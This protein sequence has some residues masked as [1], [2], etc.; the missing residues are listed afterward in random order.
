MNASKTIKNFELTFEGQG[1]PYIYEIAL[2]KYYLPPKTISI[3]K[4]GVVQEFMHK[5]TL[6]D[7]NQKG[8]TLTSKIVKGF[9]K[10]MNVAVQKSRHDIKEILKKPLT[11]NSLKRAFINA[12]NVTN[13]Y[14]FFDPHFFDGIFANSYHNRKA[15]EV[16]RLVQK[17]KNIAREY[18]NQVHFGDN[19]DIPRLLLYI[20]KKT[21]IPFNELQNYN[22]DE[23]IKAIHGVRISKNTLS[24]R[25]KLYIMR[26][27]NDGKNITELIGKEAK[28]FYKDFYATKEKPEGI[29]LKGKVAHVSQSVVRGIVKCITR[30]YNDVKRMYRQMED[31]IKGNILVTQTTD[32]EMMPA[33]RKA[34]ATITDIG[35]MLSH[36]A[37]TARELDIPCIVDTKFATQIIKDGDLVEVDANNGVVKIIKRAKK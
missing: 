8:L 20:S 19:G 1:M 35:G 32:P 3:I 11:N 30:D 34:A 4:N 16:V 31:M 22:E 28:I 25:K 26:R 37:I 33:L 18:F 36:T 21:K 29:I 7:M 2:F 14:Y 15:A 5:E 12:G 9:I 23:L 10:K 13:A 17:Y 24:A 27:S 6:T